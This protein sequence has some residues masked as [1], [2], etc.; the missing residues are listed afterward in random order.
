M[1]ENMNV[2]QR[3]MPYPLQFMSEGERKRLERNTNVC[4][5]YLNMRQKFPK[6]SRRRIADNLAQSF[7]SSFSGIYQ[8]LNRAHVW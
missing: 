1:E 3:L 8:I 5:Q 7:G 6:L 4:Q 2:A